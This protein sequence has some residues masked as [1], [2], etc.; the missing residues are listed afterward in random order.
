MN[1]FYS[2]ST[3]GFY[4]EAVNREIPKGALRISPELHRELLAGQAA[5]KVIVP[6]GKGLPV[7]ADPPAEVMT[8][9]RVR[10]LRRAAYREESDHLK[11][12]AE[13]DALASAGE[14][15]YSAWLA[16]VAEIKARF[17]LPE[18]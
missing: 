11:T 8:A 2:A 17:P 7:L 5:G 3:G 18:Q 14:P 16:K 10:D 4:D 9:D 15:D 12:E 1:I 6:D 13:H